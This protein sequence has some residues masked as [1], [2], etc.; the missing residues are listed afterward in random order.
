MFNRFMNLLFISIGFTTMASESRAEQQYIAHM[1]IY[2]MAGKF[3][4]SKSYPFPVAKQKCENISRENARSWAAEAKQVSDFVVRVPQDGNSYRMFVCL[5]KDAKVQK[6]VP[7][8][9]TT[10]SIKQWVLFPPNVDTSKSYAYRVV[11]EY[12]S[13][14][15]KG[16]TSYSLYNTLAECEAQFARYIDKEIESAPASNNKVVRISDRVVRVGAYTHTFW[17][18]E[19]TY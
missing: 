10:E 12:K 16:V 1:V 5:P 19:S 14:H 17:C 15:R 3:L 9:H 7:K 13:D 2:D 8:Q 4:A 18:Q 6:N 11:H